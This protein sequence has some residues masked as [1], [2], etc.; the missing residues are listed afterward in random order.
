MH[1]FQA[2]KK[3]ES[4]GGEERVEGVE[5]TITPVEASLDPGSDKD[6]PALES[7]NLKDSRDP[8]LRDEL[9]QTECL[10]PGVVDVV[11]QTDIVMSQVSLIVK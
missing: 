3:Q 11:V 5:E 8:L 4:V 6:T 2:V 10:V 7:G 1:G 9:T